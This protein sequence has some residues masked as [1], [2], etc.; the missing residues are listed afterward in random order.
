MIGQAIQIFR[1][2]ADV[3]EGAKEAFKQ[4]LGYIESNY[5]KGSQEYKEKYQVAK[6]Q[7][8]NVVNSEK[9]K[10][11]EGITNALKDAREKLSAAALVQT[12]ADVVNMLQMIEGVP[13]GE[14]EKQLFYDKCKNNYLALMKLT[15][16]I[17]Y[18]DQEKPVSYEALSKDINEL[19]RNLTDAI[20][21]D[22]TGLEMT[23]IYTDKEMET[24]DEQVNAFIEQY[25]A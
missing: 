15:S 20:K 1:D 21:G 10:A 12:P 5:L 22:K 16:I 13:H 14:N 17:E 7:Y 24:L 4:A 3:V 6:E 23:L 8:D 18:S 19:E 9:E 25:A 2:Y 11:Q